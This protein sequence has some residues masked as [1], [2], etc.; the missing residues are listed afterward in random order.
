MATIRK[1]SF[2]QKDLIK[3]SNEIRR[4]VFIEEQHVDPEIEYEHEEEGNYYLLFDENKPIATA[5][6]R[7]TGKGIK[8]ERFALLKE[9]RNK[10]LGTLL[11]NEVIRDV[12][13]FGQRIYLHSQV[14]AVNYYK[15]AGF[16]ESGPHFTEADIAHVLMTYEGHIA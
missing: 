8:L 12:A 9:F 5:R 4:I 13:P 2:D 16:A 3:I 15:R 6:W 7:M 1:F 14:A 11:L 10:G